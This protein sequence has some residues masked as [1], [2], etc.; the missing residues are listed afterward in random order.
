MSEIRPAGNLHGELLLVNLEMLEQNPGR[1][2]GQPDV[3]PGSLTEPHRRLVKQNV[4]PQ[5][6]ERK[7]GVE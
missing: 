5:V 6:L 1:C 3:L 7:I 4:A 2:L